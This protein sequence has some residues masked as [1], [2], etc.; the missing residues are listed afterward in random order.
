MEWIHLM[1][2]VLVTGGAGY[3]GSQVCKAL[4]EASCC[5]ITFDNLSRGHRSAVRWGPL[6]VGEL[7]DTARLRR[8]LSHHSIDAIIHLA[9]YAYVGESMASPGMYFRN[10]V[11]G[12]LSLLDA[13]SDAGVR[14]L[15]FSSTCA[16]FGVPCRLPI[17]DDHPQKPVNPYGESKLTVERMLRWH[18]E[19][20][21]LPWVALRYFN[22]AGADVGGELGENHDPETHLVPL[23]IEAALGQRPSVVVFGTDY[24][25]PDGTAVRD[26]VHVSDLAD[27]HVR[28]LD[29]LLR[30]G[31]ST[32]FNLGSARGYSVQEVIQAVERASH[33]RIPVRAAPRRAGDV[34]ILVADTARAMAA[35]EWSPRCSELETIVE[36]ALN[37]H[38]AQR[39]PPRRQSI[40][41]VVGEG[42]SAGGSV[43]HSVA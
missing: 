4:A 10:N 36:T 6:E 14:P 33:R 27:A 16:T 5:P 17:P 42:T 29:Y 35:L 19:I 39:R 3:I 32:A 40:R 34:P 18:G 24:A 38:A 31:S 37:W 12:T 13:V 30:G 2:K 21:G 25:T 43:A 7:A 41:K 11:T 26:Y 9:G 15:V 22:A 1:K 28:A 20:H 23:V 8:I